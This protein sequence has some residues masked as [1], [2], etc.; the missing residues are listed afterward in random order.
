MVNCCTCIYDIGGNGGVKRR[1]GGTI[2]I[3]IFCNIN[4]MPFYKVLNVRIII[5]TPISCSLLFYTTIAF[6]SYIS[7]T[8]SERMLLYLE[9]EHFCSL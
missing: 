8:F 4:V 5:V 2:I 7:L 9:E 6:K 3:P 1:I